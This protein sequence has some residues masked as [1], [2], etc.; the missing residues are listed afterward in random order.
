MNRPNILMVL[1]DDFDEFGSTCETADGEI[2]RSALCGR[3]PFRGHRTDEED[4]NPTK[5]QSLF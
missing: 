5:E 4:H 3:D 1:A 2:G